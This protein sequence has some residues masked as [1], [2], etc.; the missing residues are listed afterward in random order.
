MGQGFGKGALTG[1]ALGNTL[2]K[3]GEGAVGNAVET[4][5][6]Y[7]NAFRSDK[8]KE[9]K[10]RKEF[11]ANRKQIDNA[12]NSF[13]KKNGKD[14]SAEELEKE[15]NDRFELSRYGLSDDEIDDILPEYQDKLQELMDK[16]KTE[17]EARKRRPSKIYF[18]I[19]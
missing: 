7:T 12:V 11:G 17:D 2:Y 3:K 14:P 10:A 15:V 13:R 16:G 6:D 1:G 5:K 9:D 8:Q 4:G 19:S 18:S